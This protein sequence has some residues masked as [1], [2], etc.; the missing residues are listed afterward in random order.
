MVNIRTCQISSPYFWGFKHDVDLD[1]INHPEEIV[2][3]VLSKLKDVLKKNNLIVLLE[4]LEGK[5]E[6]EPMHF[7]IH[8]HHNIELLLL[9][10]P[11]E[12][13]YVCSH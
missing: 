1:D 2:T 11:S 3:I 9:S 13:I 4:M 8:T 7:H 12:I 5:N 10:D 6:H